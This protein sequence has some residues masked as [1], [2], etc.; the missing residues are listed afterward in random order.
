MYLFPDDSMKN[1]LSRS[2]KTHG[3][4]LMGLGSILGTGLFVSIAIATQIAGNGIIIS[5]VLAGVLAAFNGLS[6]AQLAAAYPVSGG[7]Y[8]YGNRVLGSYWGFTAG[9]MFLIAK[10]ASAA[11]A[12]LG[13]AGY[14]FYLFGIEHSAWL[15]I[16]TALLILFVMTALVSGGIQRSNRANIMIVSL[17]IFGLMA[18]VLAAAWQN[19]LPVQP[20]TNSLT[21]VSFASILYGAALMF[22]AYTG[23]GRIAT[24]G[25]EVFEPR[26]TIPKA[27]ILAMGLIIIIYLAVSLTA[28]D[29]MGA[30]GFGQTA[31]GE[32]APLMVVAQH[33]P[34]PG[35]GILISVAA[36]TAMLG[37]LLNLLLGLSRVMLGMSRRSD[38]PRVLS[39]IN[40]TTKSPA[41]SVW[42]TGLIIG[43]L[44]LTGDI[45]FTWAFSAFTVLIYYA[46]TNLSAFLMEE[47]KRLYP[48]WIP[49]CGL[50]GCLFLAFWIEPDIWLTGVLLLGIGLIWHFTARKLQRKV[51]NGVA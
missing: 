17:T 38:L 2:I 24:L 22:V 47:D 45:R 42:M 43:A 9:W 11:T 51:K 28:I 35:L 40:H 10:S 29:V 6:S 23:Y 20:I 27:I 30:M 41:R 37:V 18:L 16:G 7:T 21:D 14:L 13:C 12:A 33:L 4:I 8:E 3:A 1:E 31:E 48:R 5:I 19:G 25:E 39:K 34:V 36:V 15:F 50:L 26:K 46:I 32:A 44:V 49:A